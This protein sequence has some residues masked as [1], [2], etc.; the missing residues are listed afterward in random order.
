MQ[1]QAASPNKPIRQ[2]HWP[3]CHGRIEL[4]FP[5]KVE[6][7]QKIRCCQAIPEQSSP[8]EAV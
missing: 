3:Q 7:S 1:E 2:R 5:Y 6:Q 4:S 8:G